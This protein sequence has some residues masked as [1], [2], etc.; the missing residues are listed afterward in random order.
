[1]TRQKKEVVKI[2]KVK[3]TQKLLDKWKKLSHE[4]KIKH[5]G[6]EGFKRKRNIQ[7]RGKN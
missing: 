1:M 3:T 5:N 7:E 4:E 6:F 2:P